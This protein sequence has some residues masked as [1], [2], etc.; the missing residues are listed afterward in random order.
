M[1]ELTSFPPSSDDAF[2]AILPPAILLLLLDGLRDPECEVDGSV[3]GGARTMG[4]LRI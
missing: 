1:E 2:D 3:E 4:V